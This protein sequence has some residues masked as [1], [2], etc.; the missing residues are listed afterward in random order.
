MDRFAGQFNQDAI[1]GAPFIGIS[2]PVIKAHGSSNET[3]FM[4]A[5]RQAIEYKKSGMIEAIEQS[6]Q[7]MTAE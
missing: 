3:A 5:I 1:G 4:N 6:V 2:R 7:H